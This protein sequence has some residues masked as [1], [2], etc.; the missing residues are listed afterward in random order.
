VLG[1]CLQA[2]TEPHASMPS[3][4]SERTKIHRALLWQQ[5]DVLCAVPWREVLQE[6]LQV[7]EAVAST[8][9]RGWKAYQ[10]VLMYSVYGCF[11]KMP[12]QLP[13]SASLRQSSMTRMFSGLMSRWNIPLRCMWSMLFISCHM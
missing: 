11:E 6:Q 2:A 10:R 3:A 13:K 9:A 12:R 5:I 7:L 4:S 1:Q 8:A